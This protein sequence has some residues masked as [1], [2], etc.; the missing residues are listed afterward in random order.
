LCRKRLGKKT[1]DAV[2]A[3]KQELAAE[4][5][6]PIQDVELHG[7]ELFGGKGIWRKVSKESRLLWYRKCID[8]LPAQGLQLVVGGCDKQKLASQ[9]A[10]PFHPHYVA[11]FL[12][13]ERI[14]RYAEAKRQLATVIADDCSQDLRQLSKKTLKQYRESGAPFGPTQDISSIIDTFNFVDSRES[15]HMQL[16]DLALFSIRRFK[17][18]QDDMNGIYGAVARQVY[19]SS[20]MPY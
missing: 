8:L 7:T 14:A 2:R 1:Q 10:N 18:L 15:E 6:L 19:L 12:C 4:L 11:L 13:L 9:Y 5:N 17:V 20:I 3:L 16:C